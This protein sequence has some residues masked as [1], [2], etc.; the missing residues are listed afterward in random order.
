MKVSEP[1]ACIKEDKESEEGEEKKK[2]LI[3][4]KFDLIIKLGA[5]LLCSFRSI[6]IYAIIPAHPH[7]GLIIDAWLWE[8][9]ILIDTGKAGCTIFQFQIELKCNE[10]VTW[11]FLSDKVSWQ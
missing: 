3:Y 9:D 10:L 4:S 6:G 2:K 8:H 11:Y 7:P 1:V 5:F